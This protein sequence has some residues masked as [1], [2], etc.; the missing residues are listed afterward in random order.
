MP[1]IDKFIPD[2]EQAALV[3][4]DIQ[5]KLAQVMDQEVMNK[6]VQNTIVLIEA[7]RTFE[8][9]I[10]MTEQYTKGLGKTVSGLQDALQSVDPLEKLAFSCC[11]DRH[12]KAALK[13]SGAKDILLC[14]IETHVCVLQ[15]ALDLLKEGYRVFLPADAVCSRKKLNW[16]LACN[17]MHDAGVVVGSTEIFIFQ[18]LRESGTERFKKLSKLI[19]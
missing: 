4:V 17:L 15:T 10:L 18:M 14:G 5:E 9:P 1:D 12:F 6:V 16:K 8:Y 13:A 2:P 19:R 11:G 3:V 7:A